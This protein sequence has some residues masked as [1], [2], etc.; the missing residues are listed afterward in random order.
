MVLFVAN[1]KRK[2]SLPGFLKGGGGF[3]HIT[4]VV[5]FQ[6]LHMLFVLSHQSGHQHDLILDF[7]GY[8][9]HLDGRGECFRC[10]STVNLLKT[11]YPKLHLAQDVQTV[12]IYTQAQPIDEK[13]TAPQTNIY[14]EVFVV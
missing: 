7:V 4:M 1:L 3:I 2:N 5:D 14:L 12:K 9:K 6:C 8:P 13:K 11:C 10:F